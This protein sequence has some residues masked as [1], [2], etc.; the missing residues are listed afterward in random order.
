VPIKAAS[1]KG[2]EIP[3]A[4]ATI[5][6][7]GQPA[8]FASAL[9]E[10]DRVF[11]LAPAE[12]LTVADKLVLPFVDTL[13]DVGVRKI[14]FMTHM[15]AYQPDTPLHTIEKSVK[16][17][18]I[19]YT[20]L[21]PNWFDQNFAPGFY[22]GNIKADGGLSLPAEWGAVSFVDTRDIGAVA[23]VALTQD[24]HDGKEYTLTGPECLHYGEACAILSKAAGRE[25]RYTPIFEEDFSK[26]SQAQ[27][28]ATE[29][30]EN[31]LTLYKIVRYGI[32]AVVTGDVASVLGRPP[33]S[34]A[35][36]AEDHAELLR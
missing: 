2:T 28:L 13:K 19:A 5:F 15:T 36:Y 16:K 24:G 1:R 8:T 29:V 9:A 3:G 30:I 35:K 31:M 12:T 22:L 20:L 4:E 26:T 17:S 34:F 21:K 23:A 18:G 7:L 33:I 11:L 25:I 27:G 6:D 32:C 10:V 14:V